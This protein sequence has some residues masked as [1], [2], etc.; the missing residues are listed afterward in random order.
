[1]KVNNRQ[2]LER[3]LAEIRTSN[4]NAGSV[5]RVN[6]PP[7]FEVILQ[8]VLDDEQAS[9]LEQFLKQKAN[10]NRRK[11]RPKWWNGRPVEI[12]AVW[13]ACQ[14]LEYCTKSEHRVKLIACLITISRHLRIKDWAT[15]TRFLNLHTNNRG[16]ARKQPFYQGTIQ[17]ALSSMLAEGMVTK[18]QYRNLVC[19]PK[20]T[21]NYIKKAGL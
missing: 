20:Q 4:H 19:N 5:G 9:E 17:Q 12:P 18:A 21:R 8:Q 13:R 3:L 6:H 11:P 7:H 14:E 1:M 15:L 10:R 16:S 2:A